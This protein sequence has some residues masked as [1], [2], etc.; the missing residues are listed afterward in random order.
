MDVP[1]ARRDLP[2]GAR[3]RAH[4]VGGGDNRHGRQH[5]RP[6]RDPGPRPRPVG[7]RRVLAR[8]PA[9]VGETR[10]EGRQ[11]RHLGRPRR[12][13]GRHRSGL[14][15][16]VAKMSCSFH[17]ECLGLRVEARASDGGRRH[18][19]G[20]HAGRPSCCVADLAQGRRPAAAPHPQAG[21]ADGR[22]RSR[23]H[24]L[25]GVSQVALAEAPFD[26]CDGQAFC[27]ASC[28]FV[29]RAGDLVAKSGA[30]A[31]SSAGRLTRA[32]PA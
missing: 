28:Y 31:S 20:V 1:L 15:S 27:R 6:A 17:E 25:H 29:F 21:G 13:E 16:N 24:R 11:A 10:A 12:F 5:R 7:G 3:E 22:G 23:R 26:G 4:R 32:L 18:Q 19:D 9:R 14:Q 30:S 8:V 2:E